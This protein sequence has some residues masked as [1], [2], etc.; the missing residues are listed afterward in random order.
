MS[1]PHHTTSHAADPHTKVHA[2]PHG[3]HVHETPPMHDAIDAWHDHSHDERPQHAHGEVQNSRL[4]LGVGL[5]LTGVIVVS[6]LVVYGF[7]VHYNTQRS[8]ERERTT[9]GSPLIETRIEKG[10]ALAMIQ[11]GG[12]FP[13]ATEDEKVKKTV[14][15]TP[16]D[17]AMDKVVRMYVKPAA[18]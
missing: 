18:K 3:H 13:M 2:P 12:S 11:T 17:Q 14:T 8:D 15:L 10:K 6:S 1:D 4:V 5:A 7:Y 9:D 16:I